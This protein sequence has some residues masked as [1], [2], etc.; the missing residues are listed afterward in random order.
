VPVDP[1]IHVL[2]PG[3]TFEMSTITDFPGE[4]QRRCLHA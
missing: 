3:I 4:P 2:P 1:T